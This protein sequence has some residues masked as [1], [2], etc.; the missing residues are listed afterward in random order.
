VSEARHD[1]RALAVLALV[2]AGVMLVGCK[3]VENVE[4]APRP[5][6]AATSSGDSSTSSGGGPVLRTVATRSPW[7]GPAQNL[8]VDGDFE[9]SI[10]SQHHGDPNAWYAFDFTKG[11]QAYLRGETGGLCRSGLR[12]AVL[13]PK[14]VLFG[15]G[16][17]PP[18]GIGLTAALWAKPPAGRGCD[19]LSA[20]ILD[21]DQ[22]NLALPMK[23][24][25][26][27]PD[28]SGWCSYAAGLPKVPTKR[29][30]YVESKL[31]AGETALVDSATILPVG[32]AMTSPA[33]EPAQVP[34][35]A[36]MG[37]T[38]AK[39]RALTPFGEPRRAEPPSTP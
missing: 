13:A 15:R 21:C 28:E 18:P 39:V 6:E 23:P 29:C 30:M 8:L 35:D 37:W 5:G 27:A 7:G 9:L 11:T 10:A 16:T 26:E 25:S 3:V 12:C 14:V 36:T 4:P 17:A 19:I 33:D 1:S 22:S 2:G 38:I 24:S 34:G 32:S 31:N 20:A